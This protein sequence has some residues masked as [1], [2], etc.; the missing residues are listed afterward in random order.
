MGT[1]L[2][3]T[4]VIY[5]VHHI[6]LGIRAHELSMFPTDYLLYSHQFKAKQSKTNQDLLSVR[7]CENNV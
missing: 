6:H 3:N 4:I 2:E 5:Q 7:K 1:A